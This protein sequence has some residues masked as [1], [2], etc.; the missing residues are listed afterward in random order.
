VRGVVSFSDPVPRRDAAG[1]LVFPGHVGLIYQASNALY[2]GRGTPRTLLVLPD[3]RVLHER[4]LA[5]ARA[6]ERG[7]GY[8][9]ELLER[10]G[11]P[12]RRGADPARWLPH[13]LAA[14]GVRRVRHPGNHRYL[15]RIG[16]RRAR[17]AVAVGPA[18]RPYPKEPDGPS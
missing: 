16:D 4:A 12:P 9:E 7:H 8:V 18:A 6:L 11:A 2:A 17:R 1:R 13:A 3:G 10:F 14:A 15:F 5:K